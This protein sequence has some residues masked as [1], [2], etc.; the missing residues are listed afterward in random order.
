[1]GTWFIQGSKEDLQMKGGY[2]FHHEHGK[3]R[4]L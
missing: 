3:E 2:K 1:M 4:L